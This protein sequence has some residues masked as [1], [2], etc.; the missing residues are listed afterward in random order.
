[1]NM[2]FEFLGINDSEFIEGYKRSKDKLEWSKQVGL[3]VIAYY[4]KRIAEGKATNSA[5]SE[6]R[7]IRAFCRDNATTLQIKRGRIL[8][9][10]VH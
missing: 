4:N 9:R 6:T 2:F 3:K 10:K 1:M 5:R 8:R 7:T